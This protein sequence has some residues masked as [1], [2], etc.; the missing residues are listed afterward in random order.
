MN[1]QPRP[2]WAEFAA[3]PLGSVHLSRLQACFDG[4]ELP[5][6]T[7]REM[8]EQPRLQAR[9][10]RLLERHYGLAPLEQLAPP[11]T[12]DLSASMLPA[13]DIGALSR[14]CGVVY[15]ARAFTQEIRATQVRQLREH[16][17]EAHY[18]LALHARD[19]A[20]DATPPST[21]QA[22]EEAVNRDGE[23]CLHAWLNDQPRA[24]GAWQRLKV[25]DRRSPDSLPEEALQ[26]GPAI[27]RSVVQW[28]TARG[29]DS[30]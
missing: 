13:L 15:W 19:L 7:L 14:A 6:E 10:T 24:L 4:L 30:L 26:R 2:A 9:L 21:L 1:T 29:E 28:R 17:G 12:A 11:K 27:M 5:P 23:H 25:S 20:T 3:Q 22:L 16:F 8:L 18:Q